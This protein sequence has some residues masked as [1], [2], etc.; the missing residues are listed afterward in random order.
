MA[1]ELNEN[2][3]ALVSGNSPDIVHNNYRALFTKQQAKNSGVLRKQGRR[4][5]LPQRGRRSARVGGERTLVAIGRG[6][7]RSGYCL[8]FVQR[9]LALGSSIL[10]QPIKSVF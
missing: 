1:A 7:L 3:I 5:G 6:G 10:G 2:K 8:G 4:R 9:D